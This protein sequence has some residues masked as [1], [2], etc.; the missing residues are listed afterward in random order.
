MPIGR[1]A[2][3]SGTPITTLRYYERR[4]L[5][6]PPARV[7]GKRRYGPEVLMRLMLIRFCRIAGLGLGEIGEV[8]GDG[9]PDRTTTKRIA[10]E[11]VAAIDAQ[12]E[13]LTLARDMMTA[14]SVCTCPNV[15]QCTCG[16]LGPVI[17]RVRT[18]EVRF[19]QG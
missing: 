1:I 17:D 7:G 8:V 16:A 3:L 9:T 2:E 10:R 13:R 5:I 4:G 6:D 15:E 11:R 19:D 12:I 14:A 18:A